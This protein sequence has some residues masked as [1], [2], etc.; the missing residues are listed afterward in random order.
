MI[1]VSTTISDQ[2]C[3]YTQQYYIINNTEI[4]IGDFIE[5]NLQYNGA[6]YPLIMHYRT[7]TAA[8]IRIH[9]ANIAVDGGGGVD[10]DADL[11]VTFRK[12]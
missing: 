4:G 9:L 6:G 8:Q 11:V 12:I 1:S 10:T 5:C 3:Q 7:D 2:Y